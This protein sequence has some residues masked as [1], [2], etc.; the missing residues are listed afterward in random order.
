MIETKQLQYLVVCAEL[1][2]F[3][4]AADV[5]Y[6]TQPNISK[7]IRSLEAE[8]GFSLFER[9][10]R[11]TCLTK[12]GKHVYEYACKVLDHINQLAASAKIDAEEELLV[13][14]NPSSW[15]AVCFTAFYKEHQEQDASFH[16]ITASTEDVIKR[17][18][19]GRSDV[20]FVHVMEE[21]MLPFQYRL[22]R[23]HLRFVELKKVRAMLYF[24][25]QN[26]LGQKASVKEIP[27]EKVRL[28]Q[29]YEDEFTLDHYWDIFRARQGGS[30]D[31]Q[32]A[33]I[34]NSD[35]VMN[36]LLQHTDLGNI[37][38]AY[39]GAEERSQKFP[40]FSLYEEESVVFGYIVRKEESLGELAGQ[41]IEFVKARLS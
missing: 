33:V 36:E 12:R 38:G 4:R 9:K 1:Q 28:V 5:L 25:R 22:E 10:N 7:T 31:A 18:A 6:T 2:S 29:C 34:T 11:G 37:S 26:P 21:Q 14:C 3:S 24:G 16:I 23:N 27:M 17:C 32:V 39:L 13:A 30:L 40:G 20:G 19:D 41:Y 15:M 8:L 35:Y